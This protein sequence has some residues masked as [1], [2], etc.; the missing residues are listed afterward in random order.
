MQ[1]SHRLVKDVI[2]SGELVGDTIYFNRLSNFNQCYTPYENE[3]QWKTIFRLNTVILTKVALK[4]INGVALTSRYSNNLRGDS[5]KLGS[6]YVCGD[7]H[8]KILKTIF[9]GKN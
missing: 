9:Q 2:K 6:V 1:S 7:S 4:L 5:T 3:K 8:D